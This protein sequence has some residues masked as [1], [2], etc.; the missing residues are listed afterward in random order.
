[1]VQVRNGVLER[2]AAVN[3]G[4]PLFAEAVRTQGA[5]VLDVDWRP[6][7]GGDPA[8]VHA[9][10]RLWGVHAELVSRANDEVLA[11][12]ESATPR[13][14]TVARA[15]D[16]LPVLGGRALI[17]SGPAIEW[18]R[19]CDPQRRALVAACLFEGWA[20]DREHAAALLA[21]GDIA[22][23]P[24]NEHNHVG[25]MTGVCS[26]SMPVWVVEDEASGTRAYSTLNEGPGRTLWFGV[27]DDESIDRL[28][29]FRDDLGPAL[30]RL[31]ERC[32]PVDIFALAAQ[33]LQMG[34]DLHMRSQA[35]GNLLTRDLLAGFAALG[36]ERGRPVHRGQPPL[37]PQPHDGR[38][39]MRFAGRRGRVRLD[40]REP[41]RP[42]WHR[43]R[44]SARRSAGPVVL[45][46][47]RAGAGRAVAGGPH[48]G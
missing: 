11:R 4:L 17:H 12:I 27:G 7:A 29:F 41:D 23:A 3:I 24:G 6:P 40:C 32:G 43:H 42:Q 2:V 46:S 38:G 45:R 5:P 47:R 19:V 48:R 35:T 20:R 15:G 21:S 18:G 14:V 34:D 26:P 25:P 30:A 31:L 8:T 39:Q 44:D 37:L 9:L 28:R 16:T 36:G 33:G 1:M 13:A 10:E 22:L